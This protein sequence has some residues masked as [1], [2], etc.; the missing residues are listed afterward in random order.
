MREARRLQR[1]ALK[2]SATDPATG[3]IDVSILATGV[4]GT[5]RRRKAEIAM[6]IKQILLTK[7]EFVLSISLVFIYYH[8]A[9]EE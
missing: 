6:A 4:S 9:I 5:A 3:R 8:V 1:E 2:Q 7:C